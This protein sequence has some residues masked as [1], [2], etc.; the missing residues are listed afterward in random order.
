MKYALFKIGYR[1]KSL[2]RYPQFCI[3]QN[4]PVLLIHAYF[5]LTTKWADWVGSTRSGSSSPHQGAGSSPGMGKD[6]VAE[7]PQVSSVGS[8]LQRAIGSMELMQ[9]LQPKSDG[10]ALSASF[11]CR[12]R[13]YSWFLLSFVY[14][15]QDTQEIRQKNP[16]TP[17][18][19]RPASV[20]FEISSCTPRRRTG[21]YARTTTRRA[22]SMAHGPNRLPGSTRV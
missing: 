19:V 21:S 17:S 1:K 9:L 16:T 15:V 10:W 11:N 8:A 18:T 20:D 6:V 14:R 13:S 7:M 22:W 4:L 5:F 3:C 2:F 12:S